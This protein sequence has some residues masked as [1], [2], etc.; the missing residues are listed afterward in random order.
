MIT[1][2]S[3]L[4]GTLSFSTISTLSQHTTLLVT[5]SATDEASDSSFSGETSSTEH[6]A[7]TLSF[8]EEESQSSQAT[9]IDMTTAVTVSGEV[10][11]T[12]Y[13]VPTTYEEQT[14]WDLDLTVT[15]TLSS[16]AE[17]IPTTSLTS[18]LSK[19][20]N[21]ENIVATTEV[22]NIE[23][24]E[25]TTVPC[26]VFTFS[27]G[28]VV[29]TISH[30]SVP[31]ATITSR[32]SSSLSSYSEGPA[33]SLKASSLSLIPQFSGFFNY[34]VEETSVSPSATAQSTEFTNG[35]ISALAIGTSQSTEMPI[36]VS[37]DTAADVTSSVTQNTELSSASFESVQFITVTHTHEVTTTILRETCKKSET[38]ETYAYPSPTVQLYEGRA[39]SM[40]PVSSIV[41]LLCNFLSFS[42]SL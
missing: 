33:S 2:P 26:P 1:T 34:S 36:T 25:Y 40:R 22:I 6:F 38:S 12:T 11:L 16:E 9:S 41:F 20:S 15:Q 18:Q 17:V 39:M 8:P 29:T 42:V 13:A 24:T 14:L 37:P 4:Q 31:I 7:T 5:V 32:I 21:D 3:S 19:A 27:S 35:D 30:T 28:E 23:V 10:T